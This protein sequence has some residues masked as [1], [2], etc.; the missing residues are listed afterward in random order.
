MY[1]SHSS[2]A[3]I[4][5]KFG[6]IFQEYV[7]KGITHRVFYDDFILKLKRDKGTPNF[8]S[9]ASTSTLCPSYHRENAHAALR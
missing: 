5:P 4:L 9:S 1:L 6:K 8:I 2:Y 3:D 7:S